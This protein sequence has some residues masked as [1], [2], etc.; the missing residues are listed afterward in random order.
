MRGGNN[1]RDECPISFELPLIQFKTQ[2]SKLKT[3]SGQ[4]PVALEV[5]VEPEGTEGD[6]LGGALAFG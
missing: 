5:F 2:S 1:D 3:I 6:G 4:L